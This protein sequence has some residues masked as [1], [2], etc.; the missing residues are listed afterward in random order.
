MAGLG[1]RGVIGT[2]ARV[3]PVKT[4]P[5]RILISH[6]RACVVEVDWSRWNV[7]MAVYGVRVEGETELI[8]GYREGTA[9]DYHRGSQMKQA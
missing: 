2:P 4:R 5:S 8:C 3:G 1:S 9:W 7:A 6:V